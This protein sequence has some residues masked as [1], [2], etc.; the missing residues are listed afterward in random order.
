MSYTYD[1]R[2][3]PTLSGGGWNLHLYENGEAAGLIDFPANACAGAQDATKVA[4]QRAEAE[5]TLWVQGRQVYS[6]RRRRL[7]VHPV[8][9]ALLAVVVV[10]TF[11]NVLKFIF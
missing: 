5:A 8:L 2:P 6:K 4:F 7:M 1:I 11:Y 3:S 10:Y 9:A